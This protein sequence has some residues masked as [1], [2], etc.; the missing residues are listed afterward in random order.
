MS[1]LMR[2]LTKKALNLHNAVAQ[3]VFPNGA[4]LQCSVCGKEIDCST[5]DC[6]YYLGHGWPTCCGYTMTLTSKESEE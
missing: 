1:E 4:I 5:S 3:D 6:S 2:D